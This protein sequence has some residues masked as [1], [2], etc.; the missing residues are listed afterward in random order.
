MK[1][2]I[3]DLHTAGEPVR[4][5]TGGYPDLPGATIL[6]KI[7]AARRDHDA[8]RRVM[9]QEPRGHADMFGMIPVRP[10]APGA[11]IGALF[12]HHSGY[13]TMSG[14]G[15]IAFS[16]WAVESGRVTMT[17]PETRFGLEL[18]CGVV[19]VTCA[20]RNGKVA[21]TH[22]DGVPSFLSHRDTAVEVPGRGG[23]V[24]DIGYGG[25]FY[26]ILPASSLGFDF[27]AA[28]FDEMVAAA[29]AINDAARAQVKIVHPDAAEFGYLFGTILTDDAP[30]DR[31]TYHLCVFAGNQI[32][33][34]PTGGGV[35]ARMARDHARGLIKPG[36][37][38]KFYGPT[39]VPF[40]ATVLG[41]AAQGPAGGAVKDAVTI[42]VAGNAAYLGRSTYVI[43]ENDPLTRGF[44]LPDTYGALRGREA[45]HG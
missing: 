45:T 29:R 16:R 12:I 22:F 26:A 6:E 32:D 23:V 33:R 39:P 7:E 41:P 42:R 28:P 37:P 4:I 8:L 15:L 27:F 19:Q 1:L 44:A 21:A 17:E 36:V 5:V 10:S 38:R 18:P 25:A 34:S 24:L 9:M 11:A 35:T 20:I 40:E 14:H 30:T 43:E 3:T 31:P 13:S 2:E